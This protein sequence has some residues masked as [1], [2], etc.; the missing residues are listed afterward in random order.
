MLDD[1]NNGLTQVVMAKFRTDSVRST[2]PGESAALVLRRE[3]QM[4]G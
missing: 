4:H 2:L 1:M 3:A